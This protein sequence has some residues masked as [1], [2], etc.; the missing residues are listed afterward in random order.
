[1]ALP[2]GF[3]PK[4]GAGNYIRL[5]VGDNH[6]RALSDS[7]SFMEA[8][9]GDEG[10]ADRKPVR[11]ESGTKPPPGVVG[12]KPCLALFVNDYDN[13]GIKVWSIPQRMIQVQLM[14]LEENPK[15]GDIRGYDLTI[16]RVGTDK[17]TT[18]YSVMPDPKSDLSPEVQI[19]WD[20]VKQSADLSRLIVNGDPFGD[21]PAKPMADDRIPF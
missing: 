4:S 18:K 6:L 15:W 9:V 7:I 14:D 8:W 21:R 17:N 16:R 20:E 3:N 19:A 1:M 2:K 10:S 13:S 5:K 12:G 11:W